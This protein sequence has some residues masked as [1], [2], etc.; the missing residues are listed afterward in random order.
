MHM[1]E[2]LAEKEKREGEDLAPNYSGGYGRGI[3][4]P[5]PNRQI[6]FADNY[7][8]KHVALS[9]GRTESLS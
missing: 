4:L 9:S 2:Q 7:S 1:P 3:F 5:L 8:G 6:G